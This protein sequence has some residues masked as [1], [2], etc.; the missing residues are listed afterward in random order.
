[1]SG[2]LAHWEQLAEWSAV[3]RHFGRLME[4]LSDAPRSLVGLLG[5]LAVERM[6]QG[7]VC[8]DLRRA[9]GRPVFPEA[10]E[11]SWRLPAAEKL[12]AALRGSAVV[13]EPGSGRPLILD[14]AGRLYL[15]RQWRDERAVA[16]GIRARLR[17]PKREW[18]AAEFANA[19][20]K[21]FGASGAGIDWQQVAVFAA[22][23]NRFTVISGG[24]GT[25]KTRTIG[26]VLKLLRELR[27][28]ARVLLAAPTGKAA[29]RLQEAVGAIE[30]AGIEAKTLHRLLG[31][32][33]GGEF[34]HS[35]ENPLAA[36]WVI[37]DEASMVDL[38]TMAALIRAL[39]ASASLV[40]V[41]D[42]DQL[43]SVETGAVLGDVCAAVAA[44]QF[45][46][47]FAQAFASATGAK[48]SALAIAAAGHDA[49]VQLVKN[50]RQ[51]GAAALRQL[52][53]RLN[54]GAVAELKAV[55]ASANAADGLVVRAFP[56]AGEIRAAL[57]SWLQAHWP[58]P[59]NDPKTML[60]RLGSG[61]VLTALRDGPQGVRQLNRWVEELLAESGRIQV[62][63]TFYAGRPLLVTENDYAN[64]LFNG[65]VGVV[66]ERGGGLQAAFPDYVTESVRWVELARLPAHETVYAMTVHKSQ[67]SEFDDVLLLLPEANHPLLTRELVYTGLTRAR[68]SVEIWEST[69]GLEAACGRRA[70]RDTGLVDALK[71]T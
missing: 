28:E 59:T 47:A 42:K 54:A 34:R 65:D 35:A 15:L 41:G 1:M 57:R 25:G 40:L 32:R 5:A 31:A 12:I 6:L 3:S 60:A 21:H 10:D 27:P 14:A 43:A 55:A 58:E 39:P 17:A 23:R 11:A 2:D 71:T 53:E 46:E 30:G 22:L 56:G 52:S 29:A 18:P 68:R 37:V 48:V 16:E 24:P 49:V 36:D 4:R 61:R 9:A 20:V 69:G 64:R 66:L 67:G 63:G 44:N 50:Y 13:G 45:S 7:H 51:A 8:V 33:P 19:W 26:G 70:G 62:T 38:T